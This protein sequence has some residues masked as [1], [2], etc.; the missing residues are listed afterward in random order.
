MRALVVDDSLALRSILRQALT[1]AGFEVAEAGNGREALEWLARQGKPDLALV[2]WYMPE[3]DGPSF[4]RAV[5]AQPAYAGLRLLMMTTEAELARVAEVL[6][7][8][9]DEYILKPFTRDALLCKLDLLGIA[10]G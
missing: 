5:R 9:A 4:V 7:A 1:L 10:H 2:D 8:G 6:E 3:M